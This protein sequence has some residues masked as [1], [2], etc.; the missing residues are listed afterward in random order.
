MRESLIGSLIPHSFILRTQTGSNIVCQTTLPSFEAKI[1]LPFT[2]N[3]NRL[4][5]LL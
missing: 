3:P 1:D 2:G 4:A 5:R